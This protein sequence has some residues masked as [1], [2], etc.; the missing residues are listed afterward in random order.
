M[1]RLFVKSLFSLLLI[2]ILIINIIFFF[3]FTNILTAQGQFVSYHDKYFG[4]TTLYEFFTTDFSTDSYALYSYRSFLDLWLN[5]IK[6]YIYGYWE[7]SF[8][9]IGGITDLTSFFIAFG[10]AITSVVGVIEYIFYMLFLVVYYIAVLCWIMFKFFAFL[11]GN[12]FTYVPVSP[13][14][15][16]PPVL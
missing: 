14:D 8:P 12:Y 10:F 11:T 7:N 16:L 5:Q 1:Y 6:D 9:K 13:Y 3:D 2:V 15:T 4:F